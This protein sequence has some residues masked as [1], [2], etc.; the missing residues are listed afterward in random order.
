MNSF[1]HVLFHDDTRWQQQDP[2]RFYI[3]LLKQSLC[4]HCIVEYKIQQSQKVG[5]SWGV[6]CLLVAKRTST[7]ILVLCNSHL[8]C[9]Q[10][11]WKKPEAKVMQTHLL[12]PV[13]F[14]AMHVLHS[15]FHSRVCLHRL[16]DCWLNRF[17]LPPE[18]ASLP[19]NTA[20]L[21]K[22]HCPSHAD[23]SELLS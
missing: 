2:T 17:Q 12:Q 7:I 14:Q 19:P 4:K 3:L 18:Y 8:F 21:R 1:L 22:L 15:H 10:V 13:H 11:S 9:G 5:R 16:A 23:L 20:V 6:F